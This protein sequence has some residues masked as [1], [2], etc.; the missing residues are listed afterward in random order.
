[1][2]ILYDGIGCNETGEHTEI[3]R[4]PERISEATSVGVRGLSREDL[5]SKDNEFLNIMNREFTHKIWRYELE[6]I[7]RENH[8]QL[9]FKDWILPDE[10]IFFTLTDWIEYSGAE[11][12]V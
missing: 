4:T 9:Q 6:K 10:F 2:K 12:C 7:S 11:I 5:S 8:Y 1:M 3:A